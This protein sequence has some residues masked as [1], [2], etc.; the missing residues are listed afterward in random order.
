[1]PKKKKADIERL[2]LLD[3]HAIIHRAYHALPDFTGP[4]GEPTG[5]LYGL[6]SMLL[7]IAKDLRPDYIAACYDLPKP[8]IRH[9]AYEGYKGTRAKIDDAL[10]AQLSSSRRVF[11]A[12]SIPVY[13][14]E[15]FEADDLL[16]T[17][18]KKLVKDPH[19]DI[20]IASGD[21]DTLQLV[22]DARVRVY[23][24]KKGLNDTITYDATAVEERYGFS[25]ELI[26]DWKGLRGDPSDNIK[27]IPGVGEKTAT[28]LVTEFGHI[29]DM[30]RKLK[31]DEGAFVKKG[32]KPR[33][34]ALL[35]EHEEDAVF[36]KMLATIRT[37]APIAF[38]LP[39]EPWRHNVQLTRIVALFDELG[40]RSLR[41]RARNV[42]SENGAAVDAAE[43]EEA[44]S[45]ETIPKE[46]LEEAK[47]MLWLLASDFTNPSLEDV[48]AYAKERTFE[49]AYDALSKKIV[50]TGRL[51]E[52]F[53]TIEKP[54]IPVIAAMETHGVL[55]DEK[56]L[57]DIGKRYRA[58]LAK[59][60]D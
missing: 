8:T 55:V 51:K 23:T 25:P 6:A 28:E 37:D 53:E 17:I 44:L 5:A 24:L 60:E 34:I 41:D 57:A 43:A 33:M 49:A 46:K 50:A 30:Y 27:G 35:K 4:S 26:P 54:L 36:S 10:A 42:L 58:E 32:I 15:G 18:A 9:E 38:S 3:A 39:K 40:F 56:L 14:R 29:E 22:D 21:M 45:E 12:F 7:R 59:I 47:T 16:G 13:E 48:L 52:V 11:E 20:V 19:L 2:V 31:K 1:M